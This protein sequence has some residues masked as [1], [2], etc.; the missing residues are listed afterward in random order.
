MPNG[1]G[2]NDCKTCKKRVEFEYWEGGNDHAF[3]RTNYEEKW[4]KTFI[5][6][7]CHKGL[8]EWLN[9]EGREICS[10]CWRKVNYHNFD[11]I[12]FTKDV[13]KECKACEIERKTDE[14][15]E[16]TRQSE[17]NQENQEQE[18]DI[19][20][21]KIHGAD[22]KSEA[23]TINSTTQNNKQQKAP[24]TNYSSISTNCFECQKTLSAGE[25]IYAWP[26]L[27]NKTFCLTCGQ[28][29]EICFNYLQQI[30]QGIDCFSQIEHDNRLS[31][32]NK[33]NLTAAIA[34]KHGEEVDI[35]KL[36][37]S[38]EDKQ[39]L[40]EF[41]KQC[42]SSLPISK[43]LQESK[44]PKNTWILILGIVALIIISNLFM[45][46]L[47]IPRLKIWWNKKKIKQH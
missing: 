17:V 35:D 3:Y 27:P 11:H 46:K 21:E 28:Q 40:K 36:K 39:G 34:I 45:W 4:L 9:K 6:E 15:K 2:Y 8:K 33:V 37:I 41:Q 29:Q 14:N 16:Q 24:I 7:S 42:S 23:K 20:T 43:N 19:K 18:A 12:L 38:E 32:E 1:I 22:Y 26:H 31:Y 10:Q 30:M 25:T 5:C 44:E 13:G 47:V